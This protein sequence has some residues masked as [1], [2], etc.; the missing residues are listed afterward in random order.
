MVV[1]GSLGEATPTLPPSPS[2]SPTTNFFLFYY[3]PSLPRFGAERFSKAVRAERETLTSQVK[4]QGKGVSPSA[5]STSL[6]T[7]EVEGYCFF[8]SKA[9]G[10]K[11]DHRGKLLGLAL[12]TKSAGFTVV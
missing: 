9:A 3:Y 2:P 11:Q 7:R 5:H 4:G 6:K 1:T 10:G 8:N 12:E